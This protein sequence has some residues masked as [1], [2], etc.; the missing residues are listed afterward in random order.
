VAAQPGRTVEIQGSSNLQD[1]SK[2]SEHQITIPITEVPL[3]TSLNHEY[4]RALILN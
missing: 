3:P 2:V 1:W 4:F